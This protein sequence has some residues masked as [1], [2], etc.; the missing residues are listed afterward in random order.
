MSDQALYKLEPMKLRIYKVLTIFI[1][2]II[3]LPTCL[4]Q[5]IIT[6]S[7]TGDYEIV[8][9]SD[10]LS[11][12]ISNLLDVDRL[13]SQ[14][15]DILGKEG[16]VKLNIGLLETSIN[17]NTGLVNSKL[18]LKVIKILGGYNSRSERR[19]IGLE[20]TYG[21]INVI[22]E[23]D[24]EPGMGAITGTVGVEP[25]DTVYKIIVKNKANNEILIELDGNTGQSSSNLEP[26]WVINKQN[27]PN[28]KDF[29]T[30]FVKKNRNNLK[31]TNAKLKNTYVILNY[32][33]TVGILFHASVEFFDVGSS[34][35]SQSFVFMA[36]QKRDQNNMS[37][38]ID[39]WII[40]EELGSFGKSQNIDFIP[41]I[42]GEVILIKD[43]DCRQDSCEEYYKFIKFNKKKSSN[44]TYYE[45]EIIISKEFY[46]NYTNESF[47]FSAKM[48]GNHILC[49]EKYFEVDGNFKKTKQKKI[50]TY[51]ID[52]YGNIYD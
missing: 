41:S 17:K 29:I 1:F 10:D 40:S 13:T 50:I 9:I 20:G 32:H 26:N 35:T 5:E 46:Y 34:E 11:R 28:Y 7:M 42:I 6:S 52:F 49:T 44:S 12:D 19:Y 25:N 15:F 33:P 43:M 22:M 2:S 51:K 4:S 8:E 14:Y 45:P 16:I 23:L 39:D 36:Y 3:S 21:N 27:I 24:F 37:K 48:D 47:E 38:N 30:A 31:F 18:D